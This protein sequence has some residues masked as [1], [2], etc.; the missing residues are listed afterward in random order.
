MNDQPVCDCGDTGKRDCPRCYKLW[1]LD[2][3]ERQ[4]EPIVV[5]GIDTEV[6]Q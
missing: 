3:P 1:D 5:V 6:P 4:P 2:E